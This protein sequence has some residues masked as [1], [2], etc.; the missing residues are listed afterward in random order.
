[1]SITMDVRCDSVVMKCTLLPPLIMT[2]KD[3]RESVSAPILL[4][5]VLIVLARLSE[6]SPPGS[7]VDFTFTFIFGQGILGHHARHLLLTFLTSHRTVR[8][9]SSYLHRPQIRNDTSTCPNAY[10][11]RKRSVP[12]P[13]SYPWGQ[14]NRESLFRTTR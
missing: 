6:S 8:S 2:V 12:L 9:A 5:A 10:R 13:G 14:P 7:E 1:M 11:D 3:R 4:I